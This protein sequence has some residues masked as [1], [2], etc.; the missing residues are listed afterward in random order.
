M[1]VNVGQFEVEDFNISIGNTVVSS[2]WVGLYLGV[3][4]TNTILNRLPTASIAQADKDRLEGEARFLRAYIS[5]PS[6]RP[7]LSSLSSLFI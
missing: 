3:G 2:A 4:R 6:T 7:W 1:L 5:T